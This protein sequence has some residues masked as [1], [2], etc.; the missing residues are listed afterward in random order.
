MILFKLFR[1]KTEITEYLLRFK[2]AQ[3]CPVDTAKHYT[4][5]DSEVIV[6]NDTEAICYF[7]IQGVAAPSLEI[8]SSSCNCSAS[9]QC[10]QTYVLFH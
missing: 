1:R 5:L 2:C 3:M 7:F 6:N 10:F 4:D 9:E 8:N